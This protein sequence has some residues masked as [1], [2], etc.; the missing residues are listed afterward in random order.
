MQP[1]RHL[2]GVALVVELQ[3]PVEDL[4]PRGG[5]ERVAPALRGVVE[6]VVEDDVAP[7]VGFRNGVVELDVQAAQLDDPRALLGWVVDPVV[8]LR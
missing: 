3:Q 8:G 1:R 4:C 6:A 7:P 2:L 5:P